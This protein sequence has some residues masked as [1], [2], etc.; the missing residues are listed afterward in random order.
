MFK[1]LNTLD[2]ST[3][4]FNPEFMRVI[5]QMYQQKLKKM[6]LEYDPS[7]KTD[8]DC[9]NMFLTS[10]EGAPQKVGGGFFATITN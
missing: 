5:R 2:R 4:N 6:A 10:L 1:E 8:F 7:S 3:V 9:N